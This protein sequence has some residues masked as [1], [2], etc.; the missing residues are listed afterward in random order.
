M[1]IKMKDFDYKQFLIQ[2]GEM[3]GLW[4]CVGVMALL[5]VLMVMSVVAGPSAS[6]NADKLNA[7]SKKGKE[8][9]QRSQ[10]DATVEIVPEAIKNATSPTPVYPELFA[11]DRPF[12]DA[13][14][15]EDRK[16]RLP[17]VSTVD[18]TR[19]DYLLI[20]VPSLMLT[21][22]E[23]TTMVVV[24]VPPKNADIKK[25][26]E[27]ALRKKKQNASRRAK[28]LAALQQLMQQMQ[29]QGRGAGG[30][31]MMGPGA[32]GPGGRPGMGGA[33]SMPG[34]MEMMRGGGG[35][36][37]AMGP[38][39]GPMG[40]MM[41]GGG[42]GGM[43]GRMQMFGQAAG[44]FGGGQEYELRP[45]PEDKMEN[46]EPAEE[47]RPYRM[48]VVTGAFPYKQQLE[49]FKQA[50]RFPSGEKMLEDKD[51]PGGLEFAGLN[52]QRRE[53]KPGE[54]LDKKDWVD[55]PVEAN[56]KQIMIYAAEAD[57][58]EQDEKLK[59]YGI[60]PEHN[61]TVMPRPKLDTNLHKDEKYPE[62]LPASIQETLR[63]LEETTKGK[64]TV[65]G[66]KKSK[67]DVGTYDAWGDQ[68]TNPN[69]QST[70]AAP[71]G[72]I[73]NVQ[74]TRPEK[75]LVRFYDTMVR[76]GMVYQYRVQVRM[77]NPVYKKKDRAVSKN[78]TEDKEIRGPWAE[79]PHVIRIPDELMYYVVDEKRSE[80]SGYADKDKLAMQ[81]HHWLERVQTDPNNP[82]A[83]PFAGDWSIL[84]RE[85][86]KRG[87]YIGQ[88]KEVEV[89]VW[90]P[91]LKKYQFAIHAEELKKKGVRS[92]RH[93]GVPVNFNTETLLVDFEGGK[94]NY[95][96]GAS[97]ILDESPIE[98]LVLTPEGK[99]L[100]HNSK[101]D[102][103]NEE[104]EKRHKEWENTLKAVKNDE[105]GKSPGRG[106][107]GFEGLINSP[108]KKQ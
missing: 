48:V 70:P 51:L 64:P 55:L 66:K 78:I 100:V 62:E 72:T 30:P 108:G 29:Q 73:D 97:K 103:N 46:Y 11:F 106:G 25:E 37:G 40:R 58:S 101:A 63:V 23:D 4:V 81:V 7:L 94:R 24:L 54:P 76:P 49:Q 52:V 74:D 31:G 32:M 83:N 95:L 61:R 99:L 91:T 9:I 69:E 28:Q 27:E 56:M 71:G 36:P 90:W 43:M 80:S 17:V 2:K 86:V 107:S 45:V 82:A 84:E 1:A 79:L 3:I 10:P 60:I 22:K 105:T 21:R 33:G 6:A 85:L 92:R 89:P 14:A 88:T 59:S 44:A 87:E 67:F 16:W 20:N 98:A 96:V 93:T 15:A 35:G 5:L 75:I 41:G 8:D 53:G 77:A 18:D 13:G 50:L 26:N 42:E 57:K 65:A 38:G 39:A 34:M 102:T 68:D 47:I 104:R 12:F 19:F